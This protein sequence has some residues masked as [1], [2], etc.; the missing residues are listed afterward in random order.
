MAT[1]ALNSAEELVGNVVTFNSQ[2]FSNANGDYL[3]TA[4][5]FA[6]DCTTLSL[7]LAQYDPTIETNWN[8]ETDEQPFVLADINTS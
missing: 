1:V 8:P 3:V 6:D 4:V 5:G 2:L 7:A